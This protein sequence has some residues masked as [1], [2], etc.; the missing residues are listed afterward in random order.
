MAA[1]A[2][3]RAD[4]ELRHYLQQR[5]EQLYAWASRGGI[6][7]L[8]P[9]TRKSTNLDAV[10]I[11]LVTSRLFCGDEW[12][13]LTATCRAHCRSLGKFQAL[14][15]VFELQL[16]GFAEMDG[17][18][19][20]AALNLQRIDGW[21]QSVSA[22][23]EDV[24]KTELL[25][26][27]AE[28]LSGLQRGRPAACH[29]VLEI[30]SQFLQPNEKAHDDFAVRRLGSDLRAMERALAYGP[31]HAE[32]L[33]PV[34]RQR[35]SKQLG[36]H[37]DTISEV[38]LC[39]GAAGALAEWLQVM[40]A[41]L[42]E[43]PTI[44]GMHRA[45]E[46]VASHIVSLAKW[47]LRPHG[48]RRF[49]GR[50]AP[51]PAGALPRPAAPLAPTPPPTG[52][53]NF[54][55]AP[56][57]CFG[58]MV[59]QN[60][61]PHSRG[62]SVSSAVGIGDRLR[63][64]VGTS[65]P[66]QGAQGAPTVPTLGGRPKTSCQEPAVGTARPPPLGSAHASSGPGQGASHALEKWLR[67]FGRPG[68]LLSQ[69]QLLLQ[70]H[71][72]APPQIPAPEVSTQP[73]L[74]AETEHIKAKSIS[75]C[76][77]ASTEEEGNER[78]APSSSASSTVGCVGAPSSTLPRLGIVPQ[79]APAGPQQVRVPDETPAAASL[80][81]L[82]AVIATEGSCGLLELSS[83]EEDFFDIGHGPLGQ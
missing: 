40:Q 35:V 68:Q 80:A 81:S 58:A 10:L 4:L 65:P 1:M 8:D 56:R 55:A 18:S 33:H 50:P 49:F 39:R 59:P 46:A 76:S 5:T 22:R 21:N 14:L 74:P 62:S 28:V 77:T 66:T 12:V 75:S 17:L 60:A 73:P 36:L 31:A 70:P 16:Q 2:K 43:Y 13:A 7:S 67:E 71:A 30:A 11:P 38:A 57:R 72:K 37:A 79:A 54:A 25:A 20:A 78:A 23:L 19:D 44:R 51:P 41:V 61:L 64:A 45:K 48:R 53:R 34:L 6:A 27:K 42:V 29:I 24:T 63:A 3:V 47:S 83:D 69:Q 26:L 15:P 9:E 32:Q 52:T 82:T